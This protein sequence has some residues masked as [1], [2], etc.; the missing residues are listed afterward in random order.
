MPLPLSVLDLSVV[1]GELESR[2]R[3]LGA[4]GETTDWSTSG[5]HIYTVRATKRT[6]IDEQRRMIDAFRVA[7][8][9]IVRSP[10]AKKVLGW[11]KRGDPRFEIV[12]IDLNKYQ[13][14]TRLQS[15]DSEVVS[16]WVRDSKGDGEA[17]VVFP[18]ALVHDGRFVEMALSELA[19]A[20]RAEAGYTGPT[21]AA[22]GAKDDEEPLQ[23]RRRRLSA[24]WLTAAEVSKRLGSTAGNASEAASA[25]RKS[26]R[27]LGVWCAPDRAYRYPPWQFNDDGTPVE[28]MREVLALMRDSGI[29][30]ET[31]RAN[32]GWPEATWFLAP[33]AILEELL[34]LEDRDDGPSPAEYLKTA[35]GKVLKAAREEFMEEPDGRGG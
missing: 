32:E 9:E 22:E 24:D 29:R 28:A 14:I 16:S 7:A 17:L 15:L 8:Q 27:L 21:P 2:V 3:R 5:L 10:T 1:D 12:R 11:T 6:L 18:D 34:G 4:G 31:S 25:A 23:V 20:A 30:G 26:G 35:P 33:N 13:I 19:S